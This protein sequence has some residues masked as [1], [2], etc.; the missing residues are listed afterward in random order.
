MPR[1]PLYGVSTVF[2]YQE[3][4]IVSY[5]RLY[6]K[7]YMQFLG[8]GAPETLVCTPTGAGAGNS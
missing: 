4:R 7:A 3:L 8:L 5:I 6:C 2:T 1:N